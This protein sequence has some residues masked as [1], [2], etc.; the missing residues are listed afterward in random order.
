MKLLNKWLFISAICCVGLFA[1][2]TTNANSS[3][4]SKLKIVTSFSI[5]ADITR[6]IA[7][8]KA[9]INTII[10]RNSDAH[11]FE[12]TPKSVKQLAAAD[13]LIINGLDFEPW[14]DRLKQAAGFQA[15]ELIATNGLDLLHLNNNHNIDLKHHHKDDHENNHHHG[16]IDPHAWQSL[17][18]AEKY[19]QNI[20]AA[21]IAI[22]PDNSDF[23]QTNAN[24]YI[25][26]IREL[27]KYIRTELNAVADDKKVVLTSH[28][29]FGYFGREYD[30]NFISI[31]GL[32]STAEPSAKRIANISRTI[33]E[34]HVAAMFLESMINN[35]IL[36][37]I[38]RETGSNIGGTLYSDALASDDSLASTY[39]G[40][41][42]WNSEQII[43]SLKHH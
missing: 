7:Q 10:G 40:M 11:A 4:S 30:I 37:Q 6:N 2:P 42:K 3:E 1:I 24:A 13:L 25:A 16:D 31:T 27:D 17:A 19:T 33:Q 36:Q 39:L 23:Y 34:Q 38:S 22:D 15:K 12:P 20:S 14:L 43:N 26:K 8:D 5:L 9:E 32:S 21:L 29:S 35:S 41:M 28:D 18:N